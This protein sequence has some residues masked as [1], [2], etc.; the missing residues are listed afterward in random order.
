M[1]GPVLR[2]SNLADLL[3][4]T[5]EVGGIAVTA[6]GCD[7]LQRHVVVLQHEFG[8]VDPDQVQIIVEPHEPLFSEQTRDVVRRQTEITGDALACDGTMEVL[9][10]IQA[11]GFVSPDGLSQRLRLRGL[12]QAQAGTQQR[13]RQES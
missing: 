10:H 9:L 1:G 3:E 6:A 2:G 8:P 7:L 11:N 12:Q 5:A 4:Y 13:L